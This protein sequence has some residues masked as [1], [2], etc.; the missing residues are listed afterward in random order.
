[1]EKLTEEEKHS[2]KYFWVHEGDLERLIGFEELKP[3]IEAE[4]PEVLKAWNDYKISIKILDAVIET[5]KAE[6]YY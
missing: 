6:G 2:I 4:Y 5:I 1:M 3:K